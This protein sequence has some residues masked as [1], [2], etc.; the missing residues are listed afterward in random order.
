MGRPSWSGSRSTGRGRNGDSTGD[1]RATTDQADVGQWITLSGK[2]ISVDDSALVVVLGNGQIINVENRPWWF[3]REQGFAAATG[4]K[5]SLTGF[6]EGD[7]FEV[8]QINNL[9]NEAMV[10]IREESGRPLWA[11]GGR[12]AA[13]SLG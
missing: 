8:G 5:I 13:Q 1:D 11:G 7:S 10:Q 2:V 12:R 6:Y 4:D 9:S 3:A